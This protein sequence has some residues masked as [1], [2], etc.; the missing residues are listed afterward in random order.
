M[1]L[2]SRR[3][4]T[5]SVATNLEYN[6]H[7][8]GSVAFSGRLAGRKILIVKQSSDTRGK[9]KFFKGYKL[10]MIQDK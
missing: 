4:K 9:E 10:T 1:V 2:T 7:T 8:T 3:T 5:E 6:Q